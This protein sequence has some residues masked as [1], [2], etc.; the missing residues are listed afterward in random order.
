MLG[1]NA[2]RWCFCIC[3]RGLVVR[4]ITSYSTGTNKCLAAGAA[5]P[6]EIRR[7]IFV[8]MVQTDP[9]AISPYHGRCAIYIGPGCFASGVS[10]KHIDIQAWM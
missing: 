7:R 2:S 8:K 6:A 3:S 4:R 10:A 9:C 1:R 5:H